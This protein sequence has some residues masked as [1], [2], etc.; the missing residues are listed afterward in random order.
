MNSGGR[1]LS[2]NGAETELNLR[3]ADRL[4]VM[5]LVDNYTDTLLMQSTDV[6]KRAMT[7]Y[8]DFPLAEHGLSCILK[9]SAGSEE[10]S[11]M[12]DTGMSA[13]CLFH[14]ARVFHKDLSKMETVFL[15]HGHFDHYGGLMELMTS[16]RKGVT[17]HVHPDAFLERRLNIPSV[18]TTK[19]QTLDE[20]ALENVGVA[21]KK[22][23]NPALMA[24]G[25]VA[26]SG[27]IERVTDFEKGFPWA[28]AMIDGN[29]VV[30]PLRD[31]QAVAVKVRDQ[32]LVVISGCAH[33]G[34]IN[35][36]KHMQKLL[37]SDKVLAV[38]GGF[39]L[40]GR[41]FDPMIAPTIEE[42][43]RIQPTYVVPMHCTG[44]NAITRFA[45]EMPQQFL[46][47]TVGTTY[48]FQ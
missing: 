43:K 29:W 17:L 48:V 18:G 20:K 41:L 33:A 10:H 4:E 5:V 39:H 25:L 21:V 34:I 44:W 28:E 14:N 22:E 42:M 19:S 46:L 26:T 6:V 2:G 15:S 27:E 47:N 3:E 35:S 12:I 7:P 11:V 38:L 13:T 16:M 24:S 32:G 30:D 31:D 40:T 37:R 8:P 1:E 45:K 36:V 9:V 23:S